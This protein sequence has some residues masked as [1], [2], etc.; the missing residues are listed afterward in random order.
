MSDQFDDLVSG[1]LDETLTEA[2]FLDLETQINAEPEH[3]R[4]FADAVYL[5]Q[6][7]TAELTLR[8]FTESNEV[9]QAAPESPTISR[10][11]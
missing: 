7:L 5:E 8:R 3:A 10:R 11:T 9:A 6:R 1:Y 4:R 2:Q